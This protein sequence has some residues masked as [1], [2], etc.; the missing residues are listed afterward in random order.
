MVCACIDIG[1]NTTR[2]LVADVQGGTLREV[3][4]Q[5][6]FTR[7]GASLRADGCVSAEKAQEIAKVV[8]DQAEAARAAG[9]QEVRVVATAAIRDA[10]NASELVE[11]VES[12]CGLPVRVLD[13]AEEARLAFLGAT[14]TLPDAPTGEVAVVD[15]GGGSTEI[16]VGRVME[17]AR[18]SHSLRLGSGVLT[19]TYVQGDP[20]TRAELER[21]REHAD[22][23][24]AGV[25]V[26]PAEVA[27]AVGGSATSLRRLVGGALNDDNLVRGLLALT[28]A[29][30]AQVARHFALEEERVRLLPAGILILQ[31]AAHRLGQALAIGC[32]GI[33]EGV[34]LET[35]S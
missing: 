25:E 26:P 21:M 35:A 10:A 31:A 29:P 32:G 11:A 5:R 4:Q 33:R 28:G 17:G 8:T 3:L 9:A 7:L 1:S 30:A 2:V 24:L 16:A 27:V 34:L 6:E 13:G 22:R 12:G 23:M 20:P 15:V 14:H 19:D 18:W